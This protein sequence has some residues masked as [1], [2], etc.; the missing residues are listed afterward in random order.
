MSSLAASAESSA[1]I[2]Q[3]IE[4]L[5]AS[6][7][8]FW[9]DDSY[10]RKVANDV[11]NATIG[12][13][14]ARPDAPFPRQSFQL[15]RVHTMQC[16]S[17]SF[18]CMAAALSSD[19][20]YFALA[21]VSCPN[22]VCTTSTKPKVEVAVYDTARGLTPA[23][24]A[25]P[26]NPVP[27]DSAEENGA[28]WTTQD[29]A[30]KETCAAVEL[31]FSRD[32]EVVSLECLY[33]DESTRPDGRQDTGDGGHHMSLAWKGWAWQNPQV[34]PAGHDAPAID[35]RGA[36]DA[37][38]DACAAGGGDAGT[39]RSRCV[40]ARI[41]AFVAEN[42][43]RFVARKSTMSDA[44]MNP[45][46]S[47]CETSTTAALRQEPPVQSVFVASLSR[48][49]PGWITVGDDGHV[50]FWLLRNGNGQPCLHADFFSDFVR[51]ITGGQPAA[52]DV[53]QDATG[54]QRYY[55]IYAFEPG[56]GMPTLRVYAQ[57]AAN[58]GQA[59]LLMEH[60]PQTGLGTPVAI[61]FTD[62]GACLRVGF[63]VQSKGQVAGAAT[64]RNGEVGGSAGAPIASSD[65]SRIEYF[66]LFGSENLLDVANA[67][68]EEGSG[69]GSH[70]EGQYEKYRKVIDRVCETR[71]QERH[72]SLLQ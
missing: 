41:Q 46:Y 17:G 13:E 26:D 60:F 54:A 67:L 4:S 66:L 18:P 69:L 29:E 31:R 72:A 70:P 39:D 40:V 15:P 11:I 10:S 64:A 19:G 8:T 25:V 56:Y 45:T 38:H 28:V 27:L 36:A 71:T 35:D 32:N 14:L 37:G 48:D 34:G 51:V 63:I 57:R 53:W 2:A 1:N 6:R 42:A 55:A 5:E 58:V 44:P 22:N 33:E 3:A 23:V 24:L 50:R 68:L 59:T 65:Y 20:R 16:G 12:A 62:S 21:R 61:D 30:L 49:R 43:R 52:V 9:A 7:K 47:D